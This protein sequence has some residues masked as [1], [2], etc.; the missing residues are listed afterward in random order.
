MLR[1]AW[2][3]LSGSGLL[4]TAAGFA[5][6]ACLVVAAWLLS[7]IAGL[8]ALGAGLLFVSIGAPERP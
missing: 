4:F 7:P 2:L 3:R 5:G 8:A 6:L 1:R